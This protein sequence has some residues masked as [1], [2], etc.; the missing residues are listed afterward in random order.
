MDRRSDP[1][2]LG[3]D[4]EVSP[5]AY[6]LTAR[7]FRF[8]EKFL[9]V[10]I[11]LHHS[12][13]Q[14]AA[15]DIF[16]FNHFARFETFIPQYMIYKETGAY[17]RSIASGE[18]FVQGDVF[19]K[20]LLD[21]GAVPNNLP[22]L[23]AFL[24]AE[25]IRGRKIIV[26]P[27]GGMVKDR[28][29]LDRRGRYSIYSRKALERRKHHTGAAVLALATDIFKS[30]VLHL[31]RTGQTSRLNAISDSLQ[32]DGMDALLT[33]ARRPTSIV[34]ANITFYPIR[35]GDNLL[36]KGVELLNRGISRR[37]SE[38]L[39]IEGNILLKHTDMDIH[40]G[41]AIDPANYW[42]FA[43]RQLLRLLIP[44]IE[45]IQD[46]FALGKSG[47]LAEGMLARSLR[48]N[49]LR[50]RDEYMRRMYRQVTVNLSHLASRAILHF[51]DTA[52]VEIEK[53][54]FHKILYL[55][56][57]NVQRATNVNLHRSIRNPEAYSGLPEG[58]CPGLAQF[59]RNAFRTGLVES[60]GSRYK[61]LPKLLKEHEID[62][63]RLE[64]P[65]A[66]YANEVA[67]I[68]EVTEAVRK[69]VSSAGE[70]TGVEFARLRF[71]DEAIGFA[72][73][74]P[75]FSK[76][77][78]RKINDEETATRGGDPFLLIPE[79]A[80]GMG[81]VLVH[82]FL[83]SPAEVRGFGDD[84]A[85]AGYPVIGVRLKG[86][87]TSPWD[88]RERAWEDWLDSVRRG[89]VIMSEI[90]P[91]ICLA[92]FSTGGALCLLLAA[93]RPSCLKGVAAVS[94]PLRFRN[95]GMIFAP[96][97][98]QANK[99]VGWASSYEGMMPFRRNNSEHP[100]INYANIP[101]RGLYELS[102][103]VEELER[104]LPEIECPVIL[105][106]G[107]EDPVVEPKSAEIIMDRLQTKD[108]KLVLV[109]SGRHGI[110]NENVGSTR[111]SV[112]EFMDKISNPPVRQENSTP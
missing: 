4:L 23:L 99:L 74:K 77:R 109:P 61:F 44:R 12:H 15:G 48:R 72:W 20:Y 111:P 58:D 14:I 86:H 63:I 53:A 90:V 71:D 59:L 35:V 105:L 87:G 94:V 65:V 51:M 103:M 93:Q 57:K 1:V 100:D 98:H 66:V 18:F 45:N 29:V 97:V 56:L 33:A 62:E 68:A 96:M 32:L 52:G 25:I 78:H 42:G 67:P 83:A 101:I 11:K 69:A 13:G 82:G 95:K 16:L 60:D 81:V 46:V 102:R 21:V 40:L 5:L 38:E 8:I 112:L 6:Q 7:I 24:T 106:Q 22:D 36:R 3:H 84:L 43:D 85:A 89:M 64:N 73:D 104:R 55:A 41:D 9:G 50:V 28:R 31:H 10:H 37:L 17:C 107:D 2:D 39:L 19:S 108:K 26:F 91:Q 34:P 30:A 79:R 70:V 47:T 27:E 80:A 110:L 88:L 75:R 92:G 54:A 76:P 49:A